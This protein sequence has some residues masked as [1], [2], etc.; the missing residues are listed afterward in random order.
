MQ[1]F[2]DVSRMAK[3]LAFGLLRTFID[4]MLFNRPPCHYSQVMRK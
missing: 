2:V 4:Q 1:A 3:E